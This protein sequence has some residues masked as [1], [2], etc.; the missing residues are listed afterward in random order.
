MFSGASWYVVVSLRSAEP[1]S[2]ICH[3]NEAF[4][5]RSYTTFPTSA[6]K[7]D[8]VVT[9]ITMIIPKIGIHRVATWTCAAPE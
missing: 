7:D 3:W 2:S 4:T 5:T 8:L 6:L 9:D 1:T